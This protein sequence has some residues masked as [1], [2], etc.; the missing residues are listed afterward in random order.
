MTAL[1]RDDMCCI[2]KVLGWEPQYNKVAVPRG[3]LLLLWFFCRFARG[4]PSRGWSSSPTTSNGRARWTRP[5][6]RSPGKHPLCRAR[7]TAWP[8]AYRTRSGTPGSPSAN[9]PGNLRVKH[10]S[11]SGQ[12]IYVATRIEQFVTGPSH[13]C[14]RSVISNPWGGGGAAQEFFPAT[15]IDS[16]VPRTSSTSVRRDATHCRWESGSG[17]GMPSLP[18]SVLNRGNRRCSRPLPKTDLIPARVELQEPDSLLPLQ[19]I[20][21][22]DASN[23]SRAVGGCRQTRCRIL[24]SCG[25]TSCRTRATFRRD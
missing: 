6:G 22:A 12:S 16:A 18:T 15:A 7:T 23:N 1:R 4:R 24:N 25:T 3:P 17:R 11:G 20:D 21:Y 14:D 19:L 5:G 8:S 9:R 13:A 2:T 10:V